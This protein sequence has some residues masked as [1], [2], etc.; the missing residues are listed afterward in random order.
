VRDPASA[1]EIPNQTL[2]SYDWPLKRWVPVDSVNVSP[3]GSAY[4]D[5]GYLVDA[6]TGTKRV[7]SSTPLPGDIVAFTSEGIYLSNRGIQ[8]AP[9]LW[10][11]DPATGTVRMV[12]GSE[13]NAGWSLVSHGAAWAVAEFPPSQTVLRLDLTSG[14][15]TTWYHFPAPGNLQTID[16]RGEPIVSLLGDTSKIGMVTGPEQFSEMRLPVDAFDAYLAE[17]GIWLPLRGRTGIELYTPEKGVRLLSTTAEIIGVAGGCYDP[18]TSG[19]FGAMW[20]AVHGG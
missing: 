8:P 12:H 14:Q 7:L 20:R 1:I 6:A 11:L 9:G 18:S 2:P 5:R 10:I 16:T 13:R 4:L 3:D 17:P 19:P 15:V